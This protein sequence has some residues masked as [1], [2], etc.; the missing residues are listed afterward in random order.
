MM[1]R[2]STAG[3]IAWVCVLA[4]NSSTLA[5]ERIRPR[6]ANGGVK[7]GEPWA[8]VPDAYQDLRRMPEWPLP[9]DLQQWQD[10]DRIK[11][12]ATL[13]QC[14]GEMPPRPD[15]RLVKVV[16][17]EDHGDFTLERIQ[18][19]N[20]VDMVVP[21]VMLIPKRR[22]GRV[23]AII[24]LHG[25]GSVSSNGKDVVATAA[26]SSQLIGPSLVRQGYIVA[27]ID[28]YFHGERIGKG[29][30]GDRDNKDAQ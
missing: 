22:Q 15:P 25:H 21:G 24:G 3:V 10:L 1:F 20:G 29:P 30:G 17:A 23:P 5:Q 4:S 11:V 6:E 28:G 8:L 14:L 26:N 19:H 2:T 16:A 27:A 13:S 9:T 18:F 7:Q 12:R